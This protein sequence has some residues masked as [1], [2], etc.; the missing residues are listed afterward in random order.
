MKVKN[1]RW[2]QA[3]QVKVN[4]W[5]WNNLLRLLIDQIGQMSIGSEEPHSEPQIA[6]DGQTEM[7]HNG[8]DLTG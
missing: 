6:V 2:N 5:R 4:R 3:G 1:K 7:G 8:P